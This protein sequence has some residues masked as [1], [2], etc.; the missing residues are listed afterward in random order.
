M[1]QQERKGELTCREPT[2]VETG[3]GR[4]AQLS[5]APRGLLVAEG[6]RV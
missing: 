5:P 1:Q 4:V 2:P 3:R 6:S